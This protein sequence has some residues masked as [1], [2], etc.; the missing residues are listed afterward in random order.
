MRPGTPGFNADSMYPG[1][2]DSFDS[3]V[4]DYRYGDQVP[5][6][7]MNI[8]RNYGSPNGFRP[9]VASFE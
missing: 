6:G 4:P 3:S 9:N 5:Q 7:S 1:Q 8:N 2:P